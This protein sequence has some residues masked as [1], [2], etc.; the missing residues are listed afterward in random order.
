MKVHLVAVQ[1][2]IIPGA[3]RTSEVFAARVLELAR[4]AVAGL[5]PGEARILAFPE[6]FALPLLFWWQTP[7]LVLRHTSALGAALEILKTRWQDAL[8]TGVFSPAAFYHVRGLEAWPLYQS[9][10]RQA[11]IE[12]GSYLVAGS[13]FSPMTD[14]EPARGNFASSKSAHNISLLFSPKGTVLSRVPKLELTSQE[15]KSWLAKGAWG[16]HV[17]DTRLGKLATL[18]CLDAF[19]DRWV[20][21]AD[22][23]GAWLLVQPSANAARWNGPWS[24]DPKQVEG[25]VWLREGLAKKLYK[26][27]N[28][29]YGI[30]P[31][32]NGGFYGL[33]FEGRSGVYAPNQVAALAEA[34]TGDAI[35]RAV[36]EIP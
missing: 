36:A 32:L 11:A 19:H 16:S 5:P 7:E 26:R 17:A 15:K 10:F 8:R 24:G 27:E 34:P 9:A 6:A 2:E 12:T 33:H 23:A 31:M 14:F 30:N 3:Y 1:A 13:I 29:R 4:K 21:Q 20:E 35:V 22:A 25:E 28:L 18:I